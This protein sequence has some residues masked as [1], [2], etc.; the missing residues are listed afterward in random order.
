MSLDI[1]GI[2]MTDGVDI[3]LPTFDNL[4][5]D[6]SESY[7]YVDENNLLQ[8][9]FY[10][11]SSGSEYMSI[12]FDIDDFD[13]DN[14]IV[15]FSGYKH[16]Y[17]GNYNLDLYDGAF[18]SNINYTIL[19]GSVGYSLPLYESAIGFSI[20]VS[21]VGS[22]ESSYTNGYCSSLKFKYISGGAD[23][24]IDLV[25][26]LSAIML[27]IVFLV[28]VLAFYERLGKFVLIPM[29]LLFSIIMVATE[30]LPGWSFFLILLGCV[31]LLVT[32]REIEVRK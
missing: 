27:L 16:G 32:Q 7:F 30:L 2:R 6:V 28:P 17:Y 31:G 3:F 26:F 21:D 18:Y 5:I 14:Y 9:K 29:I 10:V 13:S 8:Y 1:K 12:F 15:I 19:D 24:G 23:L 22:N 20:I 25:S 11:N 4:N